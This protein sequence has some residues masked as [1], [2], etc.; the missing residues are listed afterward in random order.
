MIFLE[1]QVKVKVKK[2]KERLPLSKPS[3]SATDCEHVCVRERA[4]C[5]GARVATPRFGVFSGP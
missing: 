1:D 2:G 3:A 4:V 5:V